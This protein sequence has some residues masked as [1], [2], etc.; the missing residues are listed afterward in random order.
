MKKET[1]RPIYVDLD[2]VISDSTSRF[3]DIIRRDFGK[4]VQM[5]DVTSFD[6][7]RS[8]GLSDAEYEAFFRTIHRP[9]ILIGFEPIP[10][11][12]D[13]LRNWSEKGHAISVVTGRPAYAGRASMEWLEMHRV[14][15]DTFLIVDKYQREEGNGAATLSMAEL[16]GM[17]FCYAV[18]DSVPMARHLSEQMDLPVALFDRPWNR[19]LQTNRR[20]K[21]C[22][23]WTEIARQFDNINRRQGG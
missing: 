19:M 23:T 6:L 16:T 1:M 21:R 13:V 15:F 10:G 20:V 11:A 22:R 7:G 5:E 14:P 18:E 17:A 3:V 12:I 2:D 9:D 8:F 4:K